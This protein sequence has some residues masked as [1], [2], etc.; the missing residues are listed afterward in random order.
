MPVGL[1]TIAKFVRNAIIADAIGS[2]ELNDIPAEMKGLADLAADK[3]E[4]GADDA[5]DIMSGLI[6]FM[7]LLSIPPQTRDN[8]MGRNFPES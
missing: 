2:V 4:E 3:W 7:A 6:V 1:R 8:Y 5:V